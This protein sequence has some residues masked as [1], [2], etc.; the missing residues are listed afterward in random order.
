MHACI[1]L[2]GRSQIH[3]PCGTRSISPNLPHPSSKLA[4][5]FSRSATSYVRLSQPQN[6]LTNSPNTCAVPA[7]GDM[8]SFA[9]I[10]ECSVRDAVWSSGCSAPRECKRPR[11]QGVTSHQHSL[12][13][14]LLHKSRN[15]E[16]LRISA[17]I[18]AQPNIESGMH[19][20]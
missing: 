7:L 16:C 9:A 12:S 18:P 10:G 20:C 19:S 17:T 3:A 8:E 13:A 14:P 2:K 1:L 5:L 11:R 4:Q 6:P 15:A